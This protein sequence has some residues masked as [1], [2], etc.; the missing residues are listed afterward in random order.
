[1]KNNFQVEPPVG[2]ADSGIE[3]DILAAFERSWVLDISRIKVHAQNGHVILSG[4]VP[5]WE[6]KIEAEEIV[7][8]TAGVMGINNKLTVD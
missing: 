4:A 8:H 1:M 3:D 7:R 6:M 5:A 2:T